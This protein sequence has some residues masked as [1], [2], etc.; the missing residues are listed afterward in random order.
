MNMLGLEGPQMSDWI[1]DVL[2]KAEEY[3]EANGDTT[4]AADIRRLRANPYISSIQ[5]YMHEAV[6]EVAD[7]ILEAEDMEELQAQLTRAAKAFAADHCTVHLVREGG[8]AKYQAKVVT[9]Y[10]QNWATEYVRRSFSTVDPVVMQ[11]REGAGEFHWDE[12]PSGDPFTQHFFSVACRYDVGPSGFSLTK[13]NQYGDLVSVSLASKESPDEFRGRFDRLRADF[14]DLAPLLID[15]FTD[16]NASAH[17]EHVSLTDEHLR[18][19]YSL[20]KGRTSEELEGSNFLFGSFRSAEKSIL[21]KFN[22][23]T[24]TEAVASATA[25][26]LMNDLPYLEEEIR[27]DASHPGD[28]IP[29]SRRSETASVPV[30]GEDAAEYIHKARE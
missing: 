28:P 24:L 12:L 29:D 30:F 3:L 4:L 8:R 14:R 20:A 27:A 15:V 26:G 21:R 10:S 1:A 22:A 13:S 23:R 18:V 6:E 25:L 9:T 11:C 5:M 2:L 17:L 19:L 16:L 7:R